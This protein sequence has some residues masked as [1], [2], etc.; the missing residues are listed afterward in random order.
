MARNIAD[1]F[2]FEPLE[3][4]SGEQNIPGVMSVGGK[5]YGLYWLAAYG[6]P[7]PP[8]WVLDTGL[9]DQSVK[10]AKLERDIAD[11]WRS[12]LE[13]EKDW[14]AIQRMLDSFEPQRQKIVAELE[15]VEA[16]GR[17][18]LALARL[19]LEP[20]YWAVRSSATVEDNP[21]H[22]FAGQFRS[23]LSVPAGPD[24]WVAVRKVWASAFSRE[25]LMYCAQHNTPLPRMAVILQEMA[26]LSAQD[27]SG[28]AFSHSPV[29]TFP[30]VLIQATFG[31]GPT[32]VSG[33]GGDLYSVEGDTVK[34]QPMPPDQI[35]V[36]NVENGYIEPQ[37][38]PKGTPLME[39][40]AQSL[41]ALLREVAER[42]GGPVNVEFV[43]RA[44]APVQVVQV[45]SATE[46]LPA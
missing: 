45:R 8:T 32:V 24:V 12:I 23:Y 31:A 17:I 30:G 29:T 40:E 22:S 11:I 18:S 43:W 46:S 20:K 27:R 1:R 4:G 39:E 3:P 5:G 10:R 2:L 28:V 14:Q 19:P 26:P 41:A 21:H 42:W 33:R 9:F 34:M 16:F 36:S 7:S 15:Q 38:A 25:V 35:V 37:P 44:D 6:F 13:V